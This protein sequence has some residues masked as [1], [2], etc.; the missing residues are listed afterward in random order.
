VYRGRH[1]GYLEGLRYKGKQSMLAWVLHRITGLGILIFVGAH[2]IAAFFLNAL[3]D[4]ISTTITT[5]YES[6]PVQIFI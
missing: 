3:G 2:V 5:L 6:V 1:V 4:N